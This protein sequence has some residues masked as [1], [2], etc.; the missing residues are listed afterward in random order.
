M[1]GVIGSG[2]SIVA[3]D[4]RFSGH[5][6]FLCVNESIWVMG[7]TEAEVPLPGYAGMGT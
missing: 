4:R 3:A 1:G 6:V 7:V 2:G 5:K